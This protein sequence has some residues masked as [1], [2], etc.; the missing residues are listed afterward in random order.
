MRLFSR[1]SNMRRRLDAEQ[2]HGRKGNPM[3]I[4][5]ILLAALTA[6]CQAPQTLPAASQAAKDVANFAQIPPPVTLAG[7]PATL[8]DGANCGQKKGD[9]RHLECGGLFS[10]GRPFPR[11]IDGKS[12]KDFGGKASFW[13]AKFNIPIGAGTHILEIAGPPYEAPLSVSFT[14]EPAHIYRVYVLFFFGNKKHARWSPFIVDAT[15]PEYEYV[16]TGMPVAPFSGIGECKAK[17]TTLSEIKACDVV[18]DN[19][20]AK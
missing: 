15:D 4:A 11:S 8:M 17:A 9:S 2:T 20:K 14:A 1:I 19:K 13:T 7:S 18:V 3:K 6:L 5:I 16:V 10:G 12:Y